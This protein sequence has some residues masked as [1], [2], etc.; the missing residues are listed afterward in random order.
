MARS[1]TY[2]RCGANGCVGSSLDPIIAF[3]AQGLL[4]VG[5]RNHKHIALFDRATAAISA[6]GNFSSGRRHR[7]R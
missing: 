6:N 7:R 2:D 5:D 4:L 3:D 1:G